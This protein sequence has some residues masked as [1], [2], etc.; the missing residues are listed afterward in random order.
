MKF[1]IQHQRSIVG[2]DISVAIESTQDQ[3]ISHVTT[4]LDGF[5]IGDD[6]LKPPCV[7]YE[8]KFLQKGDA[9]PHLEHD[10]M[11]TA[12]DA[13]GKTTSADYRWEDA[14]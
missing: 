2:N 11:V 12:T 7:S 1:S 3:L 5:D 10:L 9:S 6:E 8:R 14:N 4:T 13:Q